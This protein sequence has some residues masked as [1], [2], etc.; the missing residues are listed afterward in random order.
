MGPSSNVVSTV[1]PVYNNAVSI[2]SQQHPAQNMPSQGYPSQGYPSQGYP[3]QGYPSQG[4]PS[5]GMPP[6]GYPSQGMP[7]QGY[8]SQ[9]YAPTQ[10]QA[11]PS[12]QYPS[13]TQGYPSQAYPSQAPGSVFGSSGMYG[14]SMAM[15]NGAAPSTVLVSAANA[16]TRYDPTNN[17]EYT[18]ATS[19]VSGVV[20]TGLFTSYIPA[21]TL[22]Y[23][24]QA[25]LN[26]VAMQSGQVPAGDLEKIHESRSNKQTTIYYTDDLY[27]PYYA[28]AKKVRSTKRG[29]P[30]C[31]D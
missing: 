6:Q 30:G 27:P 4:Y 23:A 20:P 9:A 8:P 11:Y 10:S 31:C 7:T 26:G 1:G 22:G 28:R 21:A 14:P 3:S 12:Q 18:A 17:R 16:S 5:Q 15:P 13:P 29:K 24:P 2:P 19:H 25:S